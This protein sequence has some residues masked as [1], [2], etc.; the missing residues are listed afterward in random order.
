[1]PPLIFVKPN[2]MKRNPDDLISP[3]LLDARIGRI[4]VDR[5]CHPIAVG[6]DQARVR[7]NVERFLGVGEAVAIEIARPITGV[8]SRQRADILVTDCDQ[9]NPFS[10]PVNDDRISFRV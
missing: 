8:T 9:L 2:R 4:A 10:R 1:M 3:N 6:I 7:A 5:I